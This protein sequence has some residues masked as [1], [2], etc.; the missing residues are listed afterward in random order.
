MLSIMRFRTPGKVSIAYD[1]VKHTKT[2]SYSGDEGSLAYT[3]ISNANGATIGIVG[4]A[5]GSALDVEVHC[6]DDSYGNWIACQQ[7]V[8]TSG[9]DKV[10][11]M[12]RRKITYR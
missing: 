6:T 3:V 9:V 8:N 1:D 4:G 2:I 12:W 10:E 7:T 5:N 11:K